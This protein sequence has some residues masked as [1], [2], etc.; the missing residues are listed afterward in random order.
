[1][2]LCENVESTDVILV[3]YFCLSFSFFYDCIMVSNSYHRSLYNEYKRLFCNYDILTTKTTFAELG[4]STL[5]LEALEN[6]WFE[7]PSP[8]QEKVIPLLLAGDR[9]IIGQAHTGTWKTAAFGIPLIEKIV[10][11]QWYVQALVLTPTRELAIQVAEEIQSFTTDKRLSVATI[12][13]WQSYTIQNK[14][15]KQ[16]A[17][18]VVATP[19]RLIDHL[20]KKNLTLDNIQYFV[21]DE[22]DEM[23]NM[24]FIDDIQLI[25]S[26]AS[27]EKTML[28]FSATMP[29]EILTVAKKYMKDYEVVSV[30]SSQLTTNKT[31]QIYFEVN[32]QDRFEALCRIIDVEPDFF[33]I[34]FCRTKRD[35]EF[36]SSW[37]SKRW[38]DADALHG[39][40]QQRQRETILKKMKS[41]RITALVATDVAARWI[42]VDNVS[43]VIN[44]SLPQDPESYVHR[45]G[46]TGRAG[47][48]WVAITFVSPWEYRRLLL[49]KKITKTDIRKEQIPDAEQIIAAKKGKIVQ[50]V[51]WV[52]KEDIGDVYKTMT[53]ELLE[54]WSAEDIVSG[55]LA[56]H[57]ENELSERKYKDLSDVKITVGWKSRLF[58]AL[59]RNAGYTPKSLVD[60]LIEKTGIQ[61]RHIDDVRILD[62]FSF[63]TVPFEEAEMI[64]HTFR[65]EKS[66]GRSLVSKAK[67]KKRDGSG[68]RSGWFR[69]GRSSWGN[70]WWG[71][72]SWWYNR[73]R[74]G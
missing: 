41:K 27:V 42:D 37:L 31:D 62:E 63:V 49:V 58:I 55:L 56:I 33:G 45:V 59:G 10:P 60:Y 43:H 28:F 73:E 50:D 4:L 3:S 1:M 47:K 65:S 23:L 72:R 6:K 13:G 21:L 8:I 24:W 32:E 74:R 25:L 20:Q 67:E 7:T 40:V 15:L 44:Y 48:T 39:D 5:T 34:I 69:G 19:W 46:R 53:K 12:Y 71:N 9:D 61:S 14:K 51:Q 18:I 66:N 29:K 57:Y 11:K 70:R 17:D 26:H 64:L 68:G 52:L 22:A 30:K 36:L 2:N 54:F 16:W 35:V 38:Y